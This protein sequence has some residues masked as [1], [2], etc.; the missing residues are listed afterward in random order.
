[1]KKSSLNHDVI[2]KSITVFV[3]LM[4][5]STAQAQW[6]HLY[7]HRTGDT[8][9]YDTPIY[10]HN[11]WEYED[12]YA[13]HH[14]TSGP[15]YTGWYGRKFLAYFFTSTPL[16][17]I[18]VAVGKPYISPNSQGTVPDTTPKQ[19]YLLIYDAVQDSLIEMASVPWHVY[20]PSRMLL[21]RGRGV[22]HGLV[23][24]TS[25]SCCL[26]NPW[27]S[28]MPVI[29]YYFDSPIT[30]TDSFYVGW[31]NNSV[32]DTS[33]LYSFILSM[34]N[35]FTYIYITNGPTDWE[36]C[37]RGDTLYNSCWLNWPT[38]TY[39]FTGGGPNYV[40]ANSPDHWYS[41]DWKIPTVFPIIRVDTTVPPASYCPPV[42]NVHIHN[43][44]NGGIDVTW[45]AFVNHQY[46]YEV[47]YGPRNLPQSQ[48]E[49]VYTDINMVHVD[50]LNT[51]L[52]YGLQ[53]RPYCDD[54]KTDGPW[55]QPIYF[56]PSDTADAS[57][58]ISPL[59]QHTRVMPNPANETVTVQSDYVVFGVDVY[60]SH[61]V[62]VL[63]SPQGGKEVTFDV[64]PLPAGRYTLMIKTPNGITPKP[65]IVTH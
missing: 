50:D 38:I 57:I 25:Y 36:G 6:S 53:V 61:G 30:V 43:T 47:Q 28:A 41:M 62:H 39:K 64:N 45:D 29:E 16:E 13:N 44:G 59:A 42:E 58:D 24:D 7:Y 14:F 23:Y 63:N 27:T 20:D 8:I 3:F 37:E 12:S 10:Y 32:S 11:W 22:Q 35:S 18:G 9:K 1:M 60:D 54:E 15:I 31:T 46:G 55:C 21:L 49:S 17:I 52:Y 48:W 65:L 26:D 51:S 4:V 40:H 2:W 19:E 5:A 33:D 34:H 56:W